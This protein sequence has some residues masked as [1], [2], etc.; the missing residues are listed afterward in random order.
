MAETARFPLI[1]EPEALEERLGE[2]NLIIVDL[3]GSKVHAR[4]HIPGAV[5]LGYGEIVARRD[6]VGGLLPEETQLSQA[7]SAIGLTP[8]TH[9][10]AYDDEGGGKAARLLWT[11]DS[12]GHRAYSLLNGGLHAWA[13]EVHP[14]TDRPTEPRRSDYRARVDPQSTALATCDYILEHLDDPSVALLDARSP[15]EYRGLRRYSARAGHIPGAVNMD[16]VNGMDQ[17]RN[18]RL[19]DAAALTKELNALGVTPEKTVV[20]Y[21]QTH[22]RSAYS[23]VMLKWL[24]FPSVKGYAGSWSEWGNRDDTPVE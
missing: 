1:L 21:C 24:G 18:L 5:H 4:Y 11:F 15:E 6:P 8:E 17:N 13:N 22:H 20:T 3:S 2:E 10:V 7:M 12:I 14:L 9:V 16:W 23:Y 19:R